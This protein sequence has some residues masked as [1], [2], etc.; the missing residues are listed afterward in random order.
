MD[1][2]LS[3]PND[4]VREL[5]RSSD[6]FVQHSVTAASGDKEGW[7]VAL[8]EAAAC[9]LPIVATTHGDMPLQVENGKHGL[10]GGGRRL[11]GH[12]GGHGAART[13][14]ASSGPPW[15][16]Q[17]GG[18]PRP[19]STRAAASP[20]WRECSRPARGE[21]RGADPPERHPR[22]ESSSTV[23]AAGAA[24]ARRKRSFHCSIASERM[25]WYGAEPEEV[26]RG[27]K[28]ARQRTERYPP[29]RG[30]AIGAS[31]PGGRR[32]GPQ[33]IPPMASG[34]D[35]GRPGRSATSGRMSAR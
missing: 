6:V 30:R 22:L 8:S 31:R 27:R 32:P 33:T 35:E 15:G 3:Q 18:R 26:E 23:T 29:P 24:F 16:G 11:E 20:S 12:G 34:A 19:S 1:F 5:M 9:G 28:V 10:P 25:S 4:R 14:M 21:R 2:L 7:P 13:E 17:A